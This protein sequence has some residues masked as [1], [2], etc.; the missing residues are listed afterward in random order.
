MPAQLL[1]ALPPLLLSVGEGMSGVGDAV[2][3]AL[4]AVG[5][6]LLVDAPPVLCR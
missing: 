5:V 2:W 4:A 1:C 3:V 6:A